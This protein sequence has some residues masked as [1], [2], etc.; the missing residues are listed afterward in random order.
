M[1]ATTSTSTPDVPSTQPKQLK[2]KGLKPS[3]K[4]KLEAFRLK[5]SQATT[6]DIHRQAMD[7]TSVSLDALLDTLS[8]M[9]IIAQKQEVTIPVTTRG[10]GFLVSESFE[11]AKLQCPKATREV[12]VHACYRVSLAQHQ[13]Q[14]NNSD[15]TTELTAP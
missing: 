2:K 14:L 7:R 9:K 1:E 5:K 8:N 13:L 4:K 12:D 15:I 11:E 6:D 3:S 10:I